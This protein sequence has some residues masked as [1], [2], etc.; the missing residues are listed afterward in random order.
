MGPP[1]AWV[2][3][4]LAVPVEATLVV[5]AAE[6]P[7]QEVEAVGAAGRGQAGEPEE[8]AEGQLAA[9]VA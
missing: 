4:T 9:G 6:A 1:Q 2:E 5:A 7:G 3:G 8:A